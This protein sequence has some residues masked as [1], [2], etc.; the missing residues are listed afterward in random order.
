MKS[1]RRGIQACVLITL[2]VLTPGGCQEN[3]TPPAEPRPTPSTRAAL[4]PKP[5]GASGRNVAPVRDDQTTRRE[6]RAYIAK[7]TAMYEL[8]H[9]GVWME[10][11]ETADGPRVAMCGR[12]P[13]QDSLF[14]IR[15]FF[16]SPAINPDPPAPL[17]WR[18]S[19]AHP[20]TDS[21]RDT[22]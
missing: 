14:V 7:M 22:R 16:E 6:I 20:K 9:D 19:V 4:P 3:Q 13:D 8:P 21:T 15:L 2:L 10:M 12:V 18:V 17:V 11:A 1:I 5:L